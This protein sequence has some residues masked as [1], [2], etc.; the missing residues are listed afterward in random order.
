MGC[1]ADTSADAFE[2][3]LVAYRGRTA[4]ERIELALALSDEV[5]EVGIAGIRARHPEYTE[6][7]A[8]HAMLL[9]TLG[10]PLYRRAWPAR[11]LLDP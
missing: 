3:Q 7:Q 4:Q 10:E 11:P 2:A 5:R 1:P 8:R 6:D 9:L